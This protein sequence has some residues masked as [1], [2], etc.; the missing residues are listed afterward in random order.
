MSWRP[1]LPRWW[2]VIRARSTHGYVRSIALVVRSANWFKDVVN[3]I[4]NE[5]GSLRDSVFLKVIGEDYVRIAFETARATDPNAKLYIN[6][7]KWVTHLDSPHFAHI[8][9]LKSLD[10]ASYPKVTGMVNH[11]KKWIAA[12]VPIDGIGKKPAILLY[13]HL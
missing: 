3:E 2:T 6:D 11:V 7:Y 13:G 1:T 4:F 9:I 10:S 5:D 12:G 8:L